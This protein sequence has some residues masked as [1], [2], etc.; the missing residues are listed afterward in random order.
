MLIEIRYTPVN[1]LPCFVDVVPKK[2]V[3]HPTGLAYKEK[4]HDLWKQAKITKYQ[5][6]SS[7]DR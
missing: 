7:H 3:D 1:H 5:Q 2:G 6:D 4:I